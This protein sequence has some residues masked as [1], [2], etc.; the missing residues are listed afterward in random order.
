MSLVGTKRIRKK[1]ENS[2]FFSIFQIIFFFSEHVGLSTISGN[3][4]KQNQNYPSGQICSIIF[5]GFTTYAL[6]ST[7]AGWQW[8]NESIDGII[9]TVGNS[10][11]F[12]T[13]SMWIVVNTVSKFLHGNQMTTW[14]KKLMVNE[15][16][17][18]SLMNDALKYTKL[19]L[20]IYTLLIGS[21]TIEFGTS[22]F[23]GIGIYKI[24]GEVHILSNA[25]FTLPLLSVFL[26]CTNYIS[27]MYLLLILLTATNS[28]VKFL[29][30]KIKSCKN[31]PRCKI[32]MDGLIK[33][34]TLVEIQDALLEM[35]NKFLSLTTML[36]TLFLM[37][38]TSLT[39]FN[40]FDLLVKI[41]QTKS[42][43]MVPGSLLFWNIYAQA[44]FFGMAYVTVLFRYEVML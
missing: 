22:A 35:R 25:A 21:L 11:F 12:G 43:G 37:T 32:C 40:T 23:F 3:D 28:Q 5:L 27:I 1:T 30:A 16:K 36:N 26:H 17:L 18:G 19:R 15:K 39:V 24:T 10:L 44:I 42:L 7:A 6:I 31:T 41:M 9:T 38:V 13:C 33:V 29:I 34:L 2:T 8:S 14:F 20:L 4:F